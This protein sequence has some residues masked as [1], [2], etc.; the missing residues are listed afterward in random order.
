M[1]ISECGMNEDRPTRTLKVIITGSPRSGSSFLSGLVHHMGFDL[2]PE[3][4]IK[5]PDRYNPMGYFECLPLMRCEMEA[6]KKLGGDFHRLPAFNPGWTDTLREEKQ[7]ILQIV[8]RGKIELYKGNRLMILAD[9]F[10]ELFPRAK[11]LFI[12]RDVKDTFKSRF[13][14]GMSFQEWV[15]ITDDR[16]PKLEAIRSRAELVKGGFCGTHGSC[17]AAMGAG[18][19]CSVLTDNTPLSTETWRLSNKITAKCLDSVA[20]HG[21]PRCCKRDTFLSILSSADFLNEE[22]DVEL[23]V[24]REVECEFSDMNKD[25]LMEECDFY[26][27]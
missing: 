15:K 14:E 25:C 26:I 22:M 2:G 4:W 23:E 8:E 10:D 9:L 6:L 5:K 13:G 18:I 11:W 19:F 1:Q 27:N 24:S 17:G 21:G 20:E 16:K 12:D 3:Q 7:A